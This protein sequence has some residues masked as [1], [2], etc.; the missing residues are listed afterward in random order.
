MAQPK[1]SKKK[2]APAQE[3]WINEEEVVMF[4]STKYVYEVELFKFGERS[5]N[6]EDS[7]LIQNS[8]FEKDKEEYTIKDGTR[9]RTKTTLI[10]APKSWLEKNKFKLKT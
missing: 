7:K 4:S 9:F 10:G 1:Q 3:L 8:T 5:Y 2:K 6:L